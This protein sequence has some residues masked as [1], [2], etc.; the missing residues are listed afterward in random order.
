MTLYDLMLDLKND[1]PE[2]ANKWEVVYAKIKTH[3]HEEKHFL[4]FMFDLNFLNRVETYYLTPRGFVQKVMARFG[5]MKQSKMESYVNSL[6][7]FQSV[8]L[9][10]H[11]EK[12]WGNFHKNLKWVHEY[13][14]KSTGYRFKK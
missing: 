9:E 6:K 4:W 12:N 11:D 8:K 7:R 13:G 2:I 5:Y 1:V 3:V 10:T 14:G